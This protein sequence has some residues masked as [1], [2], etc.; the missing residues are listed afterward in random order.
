MKIFLLTK[1]ILHTYILTEVVMSEEDQHGFHGN[2]GE[3][4][5]S[6]HNIEH[7]HWTDYTQ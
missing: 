6:N 4:P 1:N 3:E 2:M 7:I 5:P